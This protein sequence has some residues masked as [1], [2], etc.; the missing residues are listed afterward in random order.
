[1]SIIE[2][3][4]KDF[5]IFGWDSDPQRMDRIQMALEK[6]G[7]SFNAFTSRTL[8]LETL[9]QEA[10]HIVFLFYQPLSLHFKETL[11]QVRQLSDEIEVILLGSVEFWPGSCS[12]IKAGL[13]NDFWIWPMAG[14]ELMSLRL[15]TLIE[16]F[17][18]KYLAEQRSEETLKIVERLD[19]KEDVT[20]FQAL[21]ASSGDFG[22]VLMSEVSS[23]SQL[24]ENL[25]QN[26]KSNFSESEFIYL[27]H[28]PAKKQ[29]ILTRTSFS[30]ESYTRG[31]TLPFD[32]ELWSENSEVHE[33]LISMLE[34][35]FHCS[36]IFMQPL[37]MA[38][39]FFGFIVAIHFNDHNF[40]L[41][42]SRYMS[43]ALHNKALENRIHGEDDFEGGASSRSF[44]LT[45][46]LEVSRARRLKLPVSLLIIRLDFVSEQEKALIQVLTRIKEDIREYD[47]VYKVD[48]NYLAVILPHC[49]YEPAAIRAE[50]IR[51]K[52]VNQGL[53]G[54][55]HPLRICIG[56]SSYPEL[57]IDSIALT[58]D[59][60]KACHQV[61]ASGKN[62]VC[63]YTVEE[64]FEPEFRTP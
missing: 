45:L 54:Q 22:L 40:L 11:K 18:Y 50:K 23:E 24:I 30:T 16:K 20:R 10:P 48:S 25:I 35:S 3:Y 28:Y 6:E 39:D 31:Q 51:R 42:T 4:K 41:K 60:Y 56:V 7:F 33:E 43:L 63:L 59:A 1:M 58:E 62:K 5:K 17:I 9:E 12:L 55:A 2:T 27:K 8:F 49:S 38:D 57:S 13:V 14:P 64:P 21:S 26:L 29:L 61:M 15:G 53:K 19:N 44:A 32:R 37:Q 36:D 34:E 52:I 47:F 46:S